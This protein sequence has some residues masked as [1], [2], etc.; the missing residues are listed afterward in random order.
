MGCVCSRHTPFPEPE[1]APQVDPSDRAVIKYNV[2]RLKRSLQ[3]NDGRLFLEGLALV[4]EKPTLNSR[5]YPRDIVSSAV[6][7][8]LDNRQNKTADNW[9]PG[10]SGQGDDGSPAD[11][12]FLKGELEHPP[13]DDRK[14]YCSLKLSL[15]SHEVVSVRWEGDALVV[16]VEVLLKSKRGREV[17]DRLKEGKL[18]GI[19]IRT[20]ASLRRLDT[21]DFEVMDDMEVITFDLVHQPSVKEAVL[22]PVTRA[23]M[24]PEDYQS[25]RDQAT[26]RAVDVH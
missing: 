26:S 21:G 14:R 7:R 24:M 25:H 20:W 17:Y 11:R 4:V 19:S 3:E 9:A 23:V 1:T 2:R 18:I 6:L 12:P 15:V 5:V 10:P 8:Y 22:M 13:Y 16:M